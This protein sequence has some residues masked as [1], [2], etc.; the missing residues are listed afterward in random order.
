MKEFMGDIGPLVDILAFHAAQRN[1]GPVDRLSNALNEIAALE[2]IYD[3]VRDFESQCIDDK[4]KCEKGDEVLC[5]ELE[6]KDIEDAIAAFMKMIR[7]KPGDVIV[8]E[9]R[10]LA[11]AALARKVEMRRCRE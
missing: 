5:P 4:V 7:D 1:Y 3:A 9:T 10:A 2:A 8:K 11:L 6:K